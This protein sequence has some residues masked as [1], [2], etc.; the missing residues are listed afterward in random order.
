MD[1]V[2]FD[3]YVEVESRDLE[4]HQDITGEYELVAWSGFCS[5]KIATNSS[6]KSVLYCN[7]LLE[8]VYKTLD[9]TK[10]AAQRDADEAYNEIIENHL[11]IKLLYEVNGVKGEIVVKE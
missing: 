10:D 5:Y 3:F 1:G 2:N 8:D 7:D 9:E 4:W 6:G 11:R